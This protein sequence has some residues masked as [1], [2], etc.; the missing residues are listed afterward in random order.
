MASKIKK[1]N[2][3]IIDTTAVALEDQTKAPSPQSDQK[4]AA[5]STQNTASK[6]EGAVKQLESEGNVQSASESSQKTQHS[7]NNTSTEQSS[8]TK[9]QSPVN[10][11]SSTV[12]Q[13]KEHDA[14]KDKQK[15]HKRAQ[16]ERA[17][18]EESNKK[19]EANWSKQDMAL[20]SEECVKYVKANQKAAKIV[21]EMGEMYTKALESG[22]LSLKMALQIY[23]AIEIGMAPHNGNHYYSKDAIKMLSVND[24]NITGSLEDDIKA[25]TQIFKRHLTYLAMHH[26]EISNNVKVEEPTIYRKVHHLHTNSID[27]MSSQLYRNNNTISMDEFHTHERDSKISTKDWMTL[28]LIARRSQIG[29]IDKE[30]ESTNNILLPPD[31]K[32]LSALR[33]LKGKMSKRTAPSTAQQ[34]NQSASKAQKDKQTEQEAENTTVEHVVESSGNKTKGFVVSTRIVNGVKQVSNKIRVFSRRVSK[35]AN[36]YSSKI[37]NDIITDIVSQAKKLSNSVAQEIGNFRKNMG[38]LIKKQQRTQEKNNT[39]KDVEQPKNEHSKKMTKEGVIEERA[40]SAHT[41]STSTAQ[42]ATSDDS[43]TSDIDTTKGILSVPG[44]KEFK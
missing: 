27:S 7:N 33:Q 41:S 32:L 28:Y 38:K 29:D 14:S 18:V 1:S 37:T 10:N 34:V 17:R 6:V 35:G 21:S 43:T 19:L 39:P 11:N 2:H 9:Q 44:S 26:E 31:S 25:S 22:N 30:E 12:N 20:W 16:K 5:T 13:K 23:K 4:S 15:E 24:A 3:P 40:Q 8:S 42:H 36:H